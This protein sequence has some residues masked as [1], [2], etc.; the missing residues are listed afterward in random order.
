MLRASADEA[1]RIYERHLV[2][3]LILFL[4]KD[5]QANPDAW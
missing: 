4:L 3:G 1:Q 5:R 2:A